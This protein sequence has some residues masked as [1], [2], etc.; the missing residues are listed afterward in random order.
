MVERLSGL[1]LDKLPY[2]GLTLKELL[3]E[4][5]M[6]QKELAARIGIKEQTLSGIINGR[7]PIS[8]ETAVKLEV[9]FGI[10]A[11]FWNALQSNYDEQK[12]KIQMIESITSEEIGL[13]DDKLYKFVTDMG[14]LQK[15]QKGVDRVI[16]FRRFLNMPN[17]FNSKQI[18]EACGF[19]RKNEVLKCDYL[20]LSVWLRICELEANKIE[21]DSLNIDRIKEN[22]NWIKSLSKKSPVEFIPLITKFFAECG[23][24]LKVVRHLPNVPVQGYIEQKE[25]KVIIC[26]T[27]RQAYADIFWFSLFHEIGHLLK[28][29]IKK[30]HLH[31]QDAIEEKMADR[32]ASNALI[33]QL[34]IQELIKKGISETSIKECAN[35]NNVD[36]G[37]IVGRLQHDGIIKYTQFYNLRKRYKWA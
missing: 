21:V 12:L 13:I 16:Q 19:F 24:V 6:Q 32:F 17:L 26:L 23:V 1:S 31:F 27:I 35:K 7:D 29:N 8:N 20:A 33:S 2:P 34:S 11:S 3:V 36:V 37:I 15:L 14:Y 18:L 10:P 22:L 5:G 4:R 9:V 30:K 28:G 25:D